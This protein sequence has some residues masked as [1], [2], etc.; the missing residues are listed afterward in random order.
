MVNTKK[1][2]KKSKKSEKNEIPL[3]TLCNNNSPLI[4][5]KCSTTKCILPRM[6][7]NENN[8]CWLCAK[9]ESK[10]HKCSCPIKDTE[11]D[12][13]SCRIIYSDYIILSNQM[14]RKKKF[15][16]CMSCLIDFYDTVDQDLSSNI[17]EEY[18]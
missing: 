15:K 4:R 8:H 17:T 3:C 18:L 13:F 1:S 12:C 5:S 11:N 2:S 16:A 6:K 10:K 14:K 9:L 7:H